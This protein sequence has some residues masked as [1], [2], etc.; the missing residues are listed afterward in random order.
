MN[1]RILFISR[2]WP[3]AVGGME[4]Y[5]VEL[6][7]GLAEHAELRKLVLAGQRDGRPPGLFA[8]GIFLLKS[9]LFCLFQGRRYD[10]VI[11]GD[12]ILFPAALVH[13][14]V[15]PSA[16]RLVVVYGLDLVFHRRRGLLPSLYGIFFACFRRCR[17][18]FSAIIAISRHTASLARA[19]G[20]KDVS[21]ITPCLPSRSFPQASSPTS[22]PTAWKERAQGIRILYFG[23]L[24][25]RK[26]A[27]WFAQNVL[28]RLP[29]EFEF[30]V[31]GGSSDAR[32]MQMLNTCPRTHCLGR[33]PAPE[34]AAM[35]QTANLVVMPN[36]HT[37]DSI[38]VEGFGLV[39]IETSAQG[40]R[41]LASRIDGIS[42][43][44]IDGTTGTLVSAGNAEEWTSSVEKLCSDAAIGI[45]PTPDSI[46]ESTRNSFSSAKQAH[47]FLKLLDMEGDTNGER[48]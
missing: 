20:L 23:R 34:L 16:K 48:K 41:L 7:I 24:V 9:M 17:S 29:E 10:R 45:G 40:A 33:M 31:V 18:C 3:P 8:Y 25:P 27:L 21:V 4:T 11:F 37:P 30:F 32:Y 47:A 14:L 13:R 26:G 6:A 43:A 39:A 36:I 12:L 42:D 38:D 44:V 1:S 19:E 15:N 35:I 46:S 28:P 2:K 22:L 5:A